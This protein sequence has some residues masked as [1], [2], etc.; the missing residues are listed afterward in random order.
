MRF[1]KTL[2]VL[3]VLTSAAL[4]LLA[5]CGPSVDT[6]YSSNTGS[7]NTG[8]GSTGGTLTGLGYTWEVETSG[9]TTDLR[10]VCYGASRWVAVGTSAGV[11]V[12][13]ESTDGKSWTLTQQNSVADYYLHNVGC[14][15]NTFVALASTAIIYSGDGVNWTQAS[16]PSSN[17]STPYPQAIAAV[18]YGNGLWV[19]VD[20]LF[21]TENGWGFLTSTD[22]ASWSET[23]IGGAYAQP[24]AIA[25]GNGLYV[26]VGYGGLLLTSPD[27]TNWTNRSFTT[28]QAM[29]GITYANGMF[30]AVANNG[31]ILTSPDGINNW[32]AYSVSSG[33]LNAVGYGGGIFL[34]VGAS[35]GGTA[36]VSTDG[37]S[38]TSASSYLPSG[39][40]GAALNGAAYGN[41]SF[42]VVGDS[43][44]IGLSH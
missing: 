11:G 15:N 29:L 1:T 21:L 8:G 25:Y 30:V 3:A 14:G 33:A 42:V 36:Y 12:T 20:D 24:T 38:W 4:L 7:N 40:Y 2:S 17:G 44:E 9:T 27:G 34:A 16:V 18:T 39:L 41:T 43:G 26:V 31:Q 13:A 23:L 5:G 35:S 10:S 6:G 19:A 22:G 32:N 37:V 28:G